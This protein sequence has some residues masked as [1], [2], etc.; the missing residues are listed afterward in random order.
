MPDSMFET[1]GGG[2]AWTEFR[3]Q[4][5]DLVVE[6]SQSQI[7]LD[8]VMEIIDEEPD[9]RK[10]EARIKQLDKGRTW[11]YIKQHVL[12]DQRNSGYVRIYYDYVP[13]VA[14]ATINAASQLLGQG[15]YQEALQML[16]TVRSDENAL[17]VALWQTGQQAEALR[18]FRRAAAQG[19]ADAQENLRQIER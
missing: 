4:L 6:G 15:R 3:D 19:N 8:K 17:G 18:C 13:D 10:R 9:A 5:N 12:K 2:E 7:G 14:A 1:V 11:Q 16:Q